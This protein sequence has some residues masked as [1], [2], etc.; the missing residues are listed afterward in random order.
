VNKHQYLAEEIFNNLPA[1]IQDLSHSP[2]S[3]DGND[4]STLVERLNLPST[5][6]EFEELSHA[7]SGS[8]SDTLSTY[9]LPDAA[10]VLSSTLPDYYSTATASPVEPRWKATRT[11][12]CQLCERE[13]I[14]LTYHHLIPR[15]T[16]AK[17]LKKGWHDELDLNRVAWLCAACHKFVHRVEP[18]EE[19]ARYWNT[20]ER[21]RERDDVQKFVAWVRKIRWKKK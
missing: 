20:V 17:V 9:D 1:E 13:W 8:V 19:L 3:V 10:V 11:E 14:P 21:L 2:S 5:W 7:M 4:N 15:S 12:A 16:H 18:N 6:L